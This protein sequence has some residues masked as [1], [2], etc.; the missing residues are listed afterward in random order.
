VPAGTSIGSSSEAEDAFVRRLVDAAV[1]P[2][3]LGR[4]TAETLLEALGA[5]ASIVYVQ[6][7]GAD[8]R[9]LGWS[10]CGADDARALARAAAQ[11]A[12]Q[13]RGLIITEALGREGR[14]GGLVNPSDRHVPKAIA[15]DRIRGPS[16][17]R[18]LRCARAT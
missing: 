18:S 15:D 16:G 7:P 10:G 3:L 2:E 11:N 13:N 9:V 6:P 8:V 12:A 1:L 14:G 5:D 17:I 4:E